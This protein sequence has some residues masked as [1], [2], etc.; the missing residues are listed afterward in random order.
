MDTLIGPVVVA[1]SW[2]FDSRWR[3]SLA[4]GRTFR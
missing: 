2:G 3:T 1:G 4:V